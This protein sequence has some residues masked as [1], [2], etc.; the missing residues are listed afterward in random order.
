MLQLPISKSFIKLETVSLVGGCVV[1]GCTNVNFG[2]PEFISEVVLLVFDEVPVFVS[3]T[4]EVV[5]FKLVFDECAVVIFGVPVFVSETV[6]QV[7][8]SIIG[9]G[10]VVTING[11]VQ[12]WHVPATC[13]LLSK[14]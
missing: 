8:G 4:P 11:A 9:E 14:L 3:D 13:I 5:Y 7:Q 12:F 1:D 10:D 2:F 6:L